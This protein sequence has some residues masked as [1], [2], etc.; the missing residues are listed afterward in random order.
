VV[1][2]QSITA[3][4]DVMLA[5]HE[6]PFEAAP[7]VALAYATAGR[8]D[9]WAVI[10]G[11]AA[12]ANAMLRQLEAIRV[13]ITPPPPTEVDPF[14]ALARALSGASGDDE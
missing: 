9:Q 1:N 11:Y 10:E 6:L 8:L 13:W 2:K 4:L 12:T 3:A 14:D 7:T 5:G